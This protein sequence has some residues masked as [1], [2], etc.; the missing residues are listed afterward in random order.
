MNYKKFY[1]GLYDNEEE[2][3]L[4]YN[5]AALEYFGEYAKINIIEPLDTGVTNTYISS[6][7]GELTC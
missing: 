4:A 7:S 5:K 6:S 3:A 2:A 1:L